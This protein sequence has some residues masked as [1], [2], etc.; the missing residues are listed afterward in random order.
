VLLLARK[1]A[2]IVA[3]GTAR[4]WVRGQVTPSD[5]ARRSV[6]DRSGH[7]RETVAKGPRVRGRFVHIMEASSHHTRIS[8]PRHL[9][10]LL[11]DPALWAWL[12]VALLAIFPAHAVLAG[13]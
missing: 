9:R 13:V 10:D 6:S 2:Q 4:R 1:V 3:S 7:A 5:T 11:R 12:I 8:S